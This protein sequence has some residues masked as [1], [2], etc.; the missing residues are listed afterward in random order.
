MTSSSFYLIPIT[1]DLFVLSACT[2]IFGIPPCDANAKLSPLGVLILVIL[3]LLHDRNHIH[4][5]NCASSIMSCH[6]MFR[7][8][9]KMTHR[10]QDG[11]THS[12]HIFQQL[13]SHFHNILHYQTEHII[14]SCPGMG[15]NF[16][17]KSITNIPLTSSPWNSA[18]L[19][20][21]SSSSLLLDD[22]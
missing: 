12:I 9:L 7:C 2:N 22:V 1:Y 6:P 3:F 14:K 21:I 20:S 13:G 10:Y 18:Y 5:A 17:F 4:C 8:V 11:I 16:I 19:C 15:L